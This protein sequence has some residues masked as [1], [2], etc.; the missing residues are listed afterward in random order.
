MQE[1]DF[2]FLAGMVGL[3][4]LIFIVIRTFLL[5]YFKIELR[6]KSA[7]NIEFIMLI[8]YLNSLD[9]QI[10]ISSEKDTDQYTVIKIDEAMVMI[11][12]NQ[13]EFIERHK[14]GLI[15]RLKKLS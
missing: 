10:V 11:K 1:Q 13:E 8:L 12:K 7:S 9:S 14:Q 15:A 2:Y 4:I 5:W 3:A 6:V